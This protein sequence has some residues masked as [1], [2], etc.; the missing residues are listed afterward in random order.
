VVTRADDEI[1]RHLFGIGFLAVKP[2][3]PAA[4]IVFAAS[5]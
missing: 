3:L 5:D 1:D 2:D 4:L